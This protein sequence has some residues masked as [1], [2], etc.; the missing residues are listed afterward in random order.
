MGAERGHQESSEAAHAPRRAAERSAPMDLLPT[1]PTPK[2]RAYTQRIRGVFGVHGPIAL[3]LILWVHGFAGAAGADRSYFAWSLIFTLAYT[4]EIV[5]AIGLFLIHAVGPHIIQRSEATCLPVP[6]AVAERLREAKPLDG[7]ANQE[8][9]DGLSSYCVR[10]C[11]WRTPDA[12]HCSTCNRC[13]GGFDH[14]CWFL[15]RCIAGDA[16]PTSARPCPRGNL[17]IFRIYIFNFHSLSVTFVAALIANISQHSS[18][19]GL[20]LVLLPTSALGLGALRRHWQSIGGPSSCCAATRGRGA[21]RTQ[22][23]TPAEISL[24]VLEER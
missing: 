20:L 13:V 10:C 15:G 2:P 5:G 18:A 8:D 14:H 12:H 24:G 17:F 19:V 11:V 3:A 23:S 22:D 7:L 16:R 21:L 9:A 1:I 4:Q 6:P